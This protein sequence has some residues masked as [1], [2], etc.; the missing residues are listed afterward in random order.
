MKSRLKDKRL[1]CQSGLENV[2]GKKPGDT[3]TPEL[4]G[5][6]AAG[7]AIGEEEF[8]EEDEEEEELDT[9]EDE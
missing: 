3:E 5:E 2:Q 7:L 6:D 9:D 4:E 8:E 1:F